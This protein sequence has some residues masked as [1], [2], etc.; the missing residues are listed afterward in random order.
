MENLCWMIELKNIAGH[1]NDNVFHNEIVIC[2]VY[3]DAQII[4]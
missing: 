3:S 1:D 2:S 4:Q